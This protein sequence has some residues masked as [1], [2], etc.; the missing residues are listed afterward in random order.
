MK[1]ALAVSFY[2][3]FQLMRFLPSFLS[4][5]FYNESSG[6]Q[7]Q[8]LQNDLAVREKNMIKDSFTIYLFFNIFLR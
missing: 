4:P 3:A 7:D 1:T 5:L 2:A 6:K 8:L